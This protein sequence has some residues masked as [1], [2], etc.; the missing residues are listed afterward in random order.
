MAIIRAFC[1][2]TGLYLLACFLLTTFTMNTAHA[3]PPGNLSVG[4]CQRDITPVT[5]S[6][7]AAYEAKFG[8][9][10]GITKS[11][12]LIEPIRKQMKRVNELDASF[13]GGGAHRALGWIY[14]KL[15]GVAGGSNDNAIDH[16]NNCLL[17]TSPSP[18]DLN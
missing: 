11:L 18:R 2:P 7:A 5:P 4:V 17:Y 8:E 3:N 15:P 9:A 1:H 12:A 10:K 6:L 14:H 13:A 16:L